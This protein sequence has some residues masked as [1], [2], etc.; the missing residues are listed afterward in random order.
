MKIFY[1]GLVLIFSSFLSGLGQDDHLSLIYDFEGSDFDYTVK[2]IVGTNDSLYV[3]CETPNSQ[4]LFF[5]IDENG[6]GYKV[7]WEFDNINKAPCSLIANDTVI[8][9]TTRFSQNG[10]GAIF[11]YCL[12]DYT[13]QFICDL[14]PLDVQDVMVKYI[15]DSILWLSSQYSFVDEGSIFTIK[16]DGTGLKKIFNDTNNENG[17]NPVDFV[18]NNDSIYIACYNGGGTP[19]PDGTGSYVS[20]GSFI[21]IKND[22]TGYEKIVKGGDGVGTQ[23]QSIIIKENKLIGLFAYSG[24]NYRVGGQFF[25]CNLNGS[26]YDSLG[27][28]RDRALTKM[29]ATDSLIYGIS[30]SQ[31]F[32][33]NPFNTEIRIFDDLYSNPDWRRDVVAN[34]AFLNGYV[35]FATQ[36]G[37]PNNGGTILR[38]T[39]KPPAINDTIAKSSLTSKEITLAQ[40]FS[41]PEGDSLSYEFDY[42]SDEISLINTNGKLTLTLLN[43]K[44]AN[45]TITAN[46]GWNGYS[47]FTITLS[48]ST[49]ITNQ[50]ESLDAMRGFTNTR[51]ALLIVDSEDIKLIEIYSLSGKL[52][53]SILNP[54]KEI[55]IS[56]L[57]K[58]VFLI[59]YS[60]NGN[61]YTKKIVKS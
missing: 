58:G 16:K 41:D 25:R 53:K 6:N 49:S 39:N 27:A 26:A 28:L 9:G 56:S 22:G 20:S 61:F 24:S 42:K 38:W 7:I 57:N 48:P 18:F 8:Y 23:P 15:T 35:F 21:R 34:P 5:R 2:A 50:N 4:G 59:K 43:Q 17:Q 52:V 47:S 40:L 60:I 10:G 1:L 32:G 30:S 12:K 11:K 29:F 44:Q 13:F 19:Y 33:I 31:I 54:N 46:D 3:I 14:K 37:G 45:I 51:N 55:D 36:Q